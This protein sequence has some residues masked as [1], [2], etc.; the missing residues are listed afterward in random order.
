VQPD[1]GFAANIST[2]SCLKPAQQDCSSQFGCKHDRQCQAYREE[3]LGAGG[4]GQTDWDGCA[5]CCEG[6]AGQT[7][8]EGCEDCC[9]E[10]V[11]GDAGQ[12][13]CEASG[14]DCVADD[15]GADPIV[16]RVGG[17]PAGFCTASFGL[18]FGFGFC[19]SGSAGGVGPGTAASASVG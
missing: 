13:D 6:G 10:P 19:A 11:C 18:G 9:A 2:T 4:F 1:N 7:D 5:V 17:G 3:V 12:T 14:C 16:I 8:C 15:L